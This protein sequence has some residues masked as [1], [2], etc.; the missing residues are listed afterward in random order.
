MIEHIKP[1]QEFLTEIEN[2]SPSLIAGSPAESF[3]KVTVLLEKAITLKDYYESE[4][5]IALNEIVKDIS[6]AQSRYDFYAIFDLINI[7]L[8]YIL[9]NATLK[10]NSKI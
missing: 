6:V 8:T 7:K 3:N 2:S 9:K 4:Y 5:L 10:V 1:I